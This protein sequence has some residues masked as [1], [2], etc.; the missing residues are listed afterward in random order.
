[1]KVE[2][3]WAYTMVLGFSGTKGFF[4][5]VSEDVGDELSYVEHARPCGL[6]Y[7]PLN[8]PCGQQLVYSSSNF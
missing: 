1:M 5:D 6:A 3:C 4:M 7:P 8:I 2:I